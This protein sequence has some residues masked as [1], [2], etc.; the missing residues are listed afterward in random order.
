[1]VL[2]A[3]GMEY[4]DQDLRYQKS[5]PIYV[6]DN[7]YSAVP[8]GTFYE[9]NREALEDARKYTGSLFAEIV[10]MELGRWSDVNQEVIR[11][12]TVKINR[13]EYGH[14]TD[15]V[16]TIG[17]YHRYKKEKSTPKEVVNLIRECVLRY[18]FTF[19]AQGE[20]TDNRP[21]YEQILAYTAQYLAGQLFPKKFFLSEIYLEEY[22]A[23]RPRISY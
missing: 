7:A 18:P 3:L 1:M 11:N 17:L 10:K 19:M 6:L 8:Y 15:L 23:T 2:K 20:S 22:C 14:L 9:R 4:F 13:N 16:G 5:F 21:E 12:T